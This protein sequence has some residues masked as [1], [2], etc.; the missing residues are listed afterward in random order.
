MNFAILNH[1]SFTT[2][3]GII[4]SAKLIYFYTIKKLLKCSS[5]LRKKR[6]SNFSNR[7]SI[8]DLI[9]ANSNLP[10]FLPISRPL[11]TKIKRKI[12]RKALFYV[13]FKTNKEIPLRS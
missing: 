2:N 6:R 12:K 9:R 10:L 1:Y 8:F 7:R 4:K 5:I 3:V 13:T 11:L